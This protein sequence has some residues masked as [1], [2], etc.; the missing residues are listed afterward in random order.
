MKTS[1]SLTKSYFYNLVSHIHP[2]NWT[3]FAEYMKRKGKVD[4]IETHNTPNEIIDKILHKAK[5]KH[6]HRNRKVNQTRKKRNTIWYNHKQKILTFTFTTILYFIS[7]YNKVP[8]NNICSLQSFVSTY[9]KT[10]QTYYKNTHIT[11][12]FSK[13][14]HDEY[15]H[16]DHDDHDDHKQ[17][18]IGTLQICMSKEYAQRYKPS[19]GEITNY[20]EERYS[21]DRVPMSELWLYTCTCNNNTALGMHAITYPE[22]MKKRYITFLLIFAVLG[23]EYFTD[24]SVDV[25]GCGALPKRLSS[26][27]KRMTDVYQ[28]FCSSTIKISQNHS[29]AKWSGEQC[30]F[31][32]VNHFENAKQNAQKRLNH[33]IHS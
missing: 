5:R 10:L 18:Y 32:C 31:N 24:S 1:K 17:V 19:S 33:L 25:V 26:M 30:H 27:K 13:Q 14:S 12:V 16:D 2:H 15:F 8:Y 3:T 4:T 21:K 9:S 20:I 23:F 6:T 29:F 28:A 22:F 7:H 11:L